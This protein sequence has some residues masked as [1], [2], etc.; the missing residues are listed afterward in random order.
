MDN[1]ELYILYIE[2]LFLLYIGS[3]VPL[4]RT[5]RQ[6]VQVNICQFELSILLRGIIIYIKK[7]K[8][9]MLKSVVN[10]GRSEL[11]MNVD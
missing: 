6:A 11:F 3:W 7:Y 8:Y 9:K 2:V 10:R 1:A 5:Q 4:V